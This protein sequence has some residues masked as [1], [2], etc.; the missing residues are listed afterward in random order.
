MAYNIYLTENSNGVMHVNNVF[1]CRCAKVKNTLRF[2]MV[3]D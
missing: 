3:K 1:C 2:T